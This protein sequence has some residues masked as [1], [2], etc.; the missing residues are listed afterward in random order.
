MKSRKSASNKQVIPATDDTFR[1]MFE[2][3]AAVMLMIDPDTGAIHGAN[4][5]AVNFY[6]YSK[7]KLCSM[8][9][10]EINTLPAEQVT[11]ELKKAAT[12]EK[13]LFIFQHRL[14]GGEERIVEVISSPIVLGDRKILFSIIH[15][16]TERTRAEEILQAS[17]ARFR[18]IID[19]SPVPMALNDDQQ[20]ITYLNTA[21]IHTFG[22]SISDIPTLADWWPNAYPDPA[23]RQWVV[24]TWQARLEQA[25]QTGKPFSPME[26]R[27]RCKNGVRRTVI[28]SAATLTES[29]AGNHLVVLHDITARKQMEDALRDSERKYQILF[30]TLNEGI[31]LNEIVY[32]EQGEMIDYR[33]LEVNQAFYSSADYTGVVVGN[34]ATKLYGMTQET[35]KEF[36]RE[37]K[38]RTTS[39]LTEMPSPIKGRHYIISTSPF[40]NGRFVTSFFDITERK[41]VEEELVRAIEK[42][43]EIDE[44]F[45]AITNQATEGIALSDLEG[46]YLFVNPAFCHMTGYSEDELLKMTVFDVKAKTQPHSSF[47]ESKTAKAGLPIEVNLRRKDGTEFFTEIIGNV[48]KINNQDIVLGTVRDISERKQIE[49]QLRKLSRAAEQ[50]Q[51]SIIITDTGGNIEYVNPK[52]TQV[53]GYQADEVM[54]RNPRIL[55]SGETTPEEYKRLWDTITAG[56]EWRGEF[57][58][59]RKNGEL[60]WESTL[61]SPVKDEGGRITH[62]V[63][64]KEDTTERKQIMDNLRDTKEQLSAIFSA[65]ADGVTVTNA[66]GQL[67]YANEVVAHLAGFSSAKE[68]LGGYASREL[69]GEYHLIDEDGNPFPPDKLPSR[70]V[71]Q[72][73]AA[74]PVVVG[75]VHSDRS[76]GWSVIKANPILDTQG[77]VKFVVT[78]TSDITELK[79]A[80]EARAESEAELRAVFASM[81]DAVL[82]IDREGVY[83]KIAPTDPSLLYKPSA[84]LLGKNLREVFPAEQAEAFCNAI[85]QVL[86]TR[87]TVHVEYQL[88]I[89]SQFLWF[90]AAISMMGE[91]N[92]LWV[93]RNI[94]DRR[95][96][97]IALRESEANLA[98]IFNATDEAIFLLNADMTMLALNDIAL[99]R[100]GLP[101]ELAL[102]RRASDLMPPESVKSRQP[103]ID[104][105]LSTGQIIEFEDKRNGRYLMNRL[106]PILDADGKV[107]RLAVYSRDIT[108]SRELHLAL[109]ESEEKYRTVANFTY[110]WETWRAPDGS[111]IYVSP[112]CQR[113]CGHS[114]AEFL[115]DQNLLLKI[116]HPEDR[117]I[118]NEHYREVNQQ[119][120]EQ[121]GQLDFRIITPEGKTRWVSHRC[122]PVFGDNGLWMGRRES[123]RDITER[124]EMEQELQAQ[125]DF[126]TQILSLMGQGLT[127][128]D[129]EGNFEFVNPAYA[130]LFGYEPSEMIGKKPADVTLPEDRATLAEQR[131]NRL[132]GKTSVYE[133]HLVRADGGASPVLITGVPRERDGKY[134][135]AI[136][137]I[138][139][140]TEQKRIESELRDAKSQLEKALIREQKL[141]KT[142]ALTGI[143]NRRHLFE[144]AQRRF[145]IA[146]R[147]KQPLVV[148]MFDVDLF[149]EINDKFGH[150]LGDQVLSG[151]ASIA[152]AEI[153]SAD[154]IGRYGGDEF[155]ILLPMTNAQQAYL[156]A[157]RILKNV[158][159]LR[160][161]SEK[162]EISTTLS[163]GIV[164]YNPVSSTTTAITLEWLFHRVDEAMYKAK[165]SGRNSAVILDAK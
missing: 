100:V 160:I 84:E 109:Q 76:I 95:R 143:S 136:A 24:E 58:N 141:S 91:D 41:K 77:K 125:H 92:T 116:T 53:T 107:I 30:D 115:E 124:K 38:T 88:M 112:A 159:A 80:E 90:E 102:G 79:R 75:S 142:D 25:R 118:V 82:V 71:A 72:G 135:G 19:A 9:I 51:V 119:F 130:K 2:S 70:L 110:D 111:Y 18:A 106:H 52:F 147:Y 54:G 7:S 133:S 1:L 26:I 14:A 31:A 128:T 13:N 20:N 65:L 146:K 68:M 87:Q 63:A 78:V 145:A 40:V 156:L 60:F 161:Q 94:T 49:E 69:T 126:V 73:K 162:G 105:A 57:H 163:M 101:R 5:A 123:N 114:A 39:K 120:K 108:E 4:Q 122:T 15:D 104:R 154:V 59:K 12:G 44:K 32:D 144:V 89:G 153:R 158:E 132:E 99:R 56:G 27:V 152:S 93:A 17:E 149:K 165:N 151:V 35:I 157:E 55:K 134:A 148:M 98:A 42:A 47:F 113:I 50:S 10:T 36:W 64:V 86:A 74:Q 28:A 33:I 21:F 139:D 117:H 45:K 121:N 16:I 127:V 61:I 155:M 62:F 138:T 6:G 96:A 103:Y 131:K 150:D 137:V 46:N 66:G 164:E 43:D 11:M 81:Q 34:L 85:R 67:I 97:E 37:H 29:F 83:R 140:L 22:Y 129:A 3:H 23:Y 48:I 8:S